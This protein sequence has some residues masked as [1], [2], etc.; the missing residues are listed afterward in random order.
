MK[1]FGIVFV[2]LILIVLPVFLLGAPRRGEII[3]AQYGY[4]NQWVE[5]TER[6]RSLIRGEALDFRVDNAT[7]GSDPAPGRTKILRLQVREKNGKTRRLTFQENEYV[8]LRGYS[9]SGYT[10]YSGFQILRGEYGAGNRMMNVTDRLNS[11]IRGGQLN[12]QV[13]N[14]NM[15]GDP[16]PGQSKTLRVQYS[17]N[18]RQ[19]EVVVNEGDNLN[20]PDGNTGYS[21]F[22]ILRGEY[23]AGNRVMDVTNRL[24]SEIRGGQLNIQVT[25]A[26]MGGDPAPGQSKTLRVQYSYN[27]RQSEVVVNEGDELRL[28]D[29]NT[30]YSGFQI[31][32]GEYGVGNR[33]MDV[34]SRLNSQI[35]G[36]QLNIQ[37]TNANMGGDPAPGQSKTLRVQYSYNGRQSEAVV[38]EGDDLRLPDG[39]TGYSGFQI[40]RGEYGAGNRVMDVTNRLNSEI[41]GGQLNVQV[42]NAN[43]GGDPAPGQSKTLRVQYSYN[44]RQSEAVV[45]EGDDL[46]LPDGNTG[47]SG[48]QIFRGEYGAGNRV[49]DVTNR[50][51]SQIR[52]GQLNIQVTNANMGGDPAPGQSKTLRVQYSYNGRQS[53]AVVNEGDELRL[54][55][56]TG[57]GAYGIIPIGTQ[58]SI[59]TNEGIDSRTANAGQRFSAVMAEDVRNSSGAVAIPRGSDIVLIIRRVAENDLVLD[60]DSLVVAGQRYVVSTV[61][62]EEKGRQGIGA[63]KRTAEMVGGGAA[64]GAIVG[65]IV[66]GGKGAAIGAGVGAAGGAGAEVLTKGKEVRIPAETLLNFKLDSDLRLERAPR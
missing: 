56:G 51:N 21:G 42:T 66:G 44:G 12:I 52:G 60:I 13:T 35:R 32:R 38:N 23:G 4:G 18:G 10:G 62:L 1:R 9:G 7:L 65:A 49:M 8:S 14:A 28:P 45:N 61:D 16:A 19:S 55:D 63:N 43:M 33:V 41:R 26:N 58:L 59:R 2:L 22:Q 15:G 46:R 29:G 39:N 40:F 17:Y 47:Y 36:G 6:V 48:F 54:P 64:L 30:G 20:L 27:G 3:R 53:E 37:V 24:N 11:Q 57:G 25:N 5:V 34:T 31:F 50:L